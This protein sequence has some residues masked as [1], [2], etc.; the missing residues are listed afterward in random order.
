MTESS[1]FIYKLMAIGFA[2]I[3][4]GYLLMIGGAPERPEI[5]NEDVFSFRRIVLAPMLI[6]VGFAIEI[7][8]IIKRPKDN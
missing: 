3:V 6:L 8:A 1:K 7:Y 5:F 2:V 4:L